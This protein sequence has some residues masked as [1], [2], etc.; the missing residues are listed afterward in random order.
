MRLESA[1]MIRRAPEEVGRF[2]ADITKIEK[3]DRGVGSTRALSGSPETVGFEFE[4]LGRSDAPHC[5]PE[6]AR[7]AYRIIRADSDRCTVAL[8]SSTGNAR[9]FKAA[10]W[11]FH[12]SPAAEGSLL[13][14]CAE[15]TLKPRYL[16]LGPVLYL[17]RS[18]IQMD[19]QGL[20]QAVEGT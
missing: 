6:Q 19:L 15:F 9:F 14:C 1:I 17:K 18:A 2:L 11:H 7:M 20:K 8:T 16:W 4:T 13:T 10:Q 12:I 3:W 5:R